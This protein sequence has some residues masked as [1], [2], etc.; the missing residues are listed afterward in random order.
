MELVVPHPLERLTRLKC[1]GPEK[2]KMSLKNFLEQKKSIVVMPETASVMDAIE[3]MI[4]EKTGAVLIAPDGK[5][6]KGIVTER[7]VMTRVTAKKLDPTTTSLSQIM[8][9]DLIERDEN[10]SID[11]AISIMSEHK[12]RHLPVV[13][14]D[15][16]IVG[17]ISLRHLLHDQIQDLMEELSSLEA[18]L[19]DAPGG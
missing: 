3:K 14:K 1:D 10:T 6:L 4:D 13:N 19:N 8:T 16:E 18:Y 11:E 9:S 2:L 5:A 12:I 7:D 17:M 15:H